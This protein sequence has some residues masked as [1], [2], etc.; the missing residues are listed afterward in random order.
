MPKKFTVLKTIFNT[1][2]P[3]NFFLL[4]NSIC[5]GFLRVL[6]AS[7]NIVFFIANN[8]IYSNSKRVKD[9]IRICHTHAHTHFFCVHKETIVSRYYIVFFHVFSF[10]GRRRRDAVPEILRKIQYV[11]TRLSSISLQDCHSLADRLNSFFFLSLMRGFLN[12]RILDTGR[13]KCGK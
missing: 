3:R 6:C 12:P 2:F 4:K 8:L 13:K 1:Y 9:I 11:C 5:R 10:S 7:K